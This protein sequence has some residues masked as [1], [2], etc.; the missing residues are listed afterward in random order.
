VRGRVAELRYPFVA[1]GFAAGS[2]AVVQLRISPGVLSVKPGGAA[3]LAK[4]DERRWEQ[5]GHAAWFRK[6]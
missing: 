3:E 4:R 1:K 6:D 2:A 5:E